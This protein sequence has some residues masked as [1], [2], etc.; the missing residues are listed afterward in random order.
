MTEP[1]SPL[2][3]LLL[4]VCVLMTAPAL[5]RAQAAGAGSE[6]CAACH[7]EIYASYSSTVMADASGPA[8]EGLVTGEFT[9]QPS[10]V[11]FRIF[12]KDQ[13]AWM[14]YDR[15]SEPGFHGQRELLYFIG[16]GVKGRSYLFP[17]QGFLFETPINWYSQEQRWNLAP[18][19]TE[20]RES[21]MNLPASVSCLNCHTSG[22]Q[23][24][25]PGT[26]SQFAGKP[27]LHSGITCQRCHGTGER[28]LDG[29]GPIVNPAKLPP[30]RRDA[31]CMECHFE[32]AVAVEQPGKSL[33]D[34]SAWRKALRLRPLFP[35]G[36][37]FIPEKPGGE[38]V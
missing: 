24:P 26:D 25:L 37:K 34:F 33:Y 28:H 2:S 16:S 36:G 23:P 9:H 14:S 7:A 20:A 15:P 27:F 11:H 21:P 30:D 4:V 29:K 35:V 8:L 1:K 22:M 10:G 31:I 6:V 38:P 18:A 32:G 13:R 19:Y 12:Q 17:L 3:S 5:S